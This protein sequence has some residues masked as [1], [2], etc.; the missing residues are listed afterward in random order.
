MKISDED[1][2]ESITLTL[3]VLS[4][5]QNDNDSKNSFFL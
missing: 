4:S 5:S 2:F 1:V 3:L